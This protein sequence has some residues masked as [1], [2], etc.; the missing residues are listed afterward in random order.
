LCYYY[1]SSYTLMQ[2]PDVQ[3]SLHPHICVLT[4][5]HQ[6]HGVAARQLLNYSHYMADAKITFIYHLSRQSTCCIKST[7]EWAAKLAG[8][9]II[10]NNFQAQTSYLCC[11]SSILANADL[12]DKIGIRPDYVY[13]HSDSDL[14]IRNGV[15]GAISQNSYGIMLQP[16][17]YAT[18][19]WDQAPVM[20]K[21][22]RLLPFLDSIGC[23]PNGLTFGRA[24]GSFF[25]WQCWQTIIQAIRQTFH[26]DDAYFEQTNTHWTAEEI[27]FPTATRHLL[28]KY[29]ANSRQP[30]V[31]VK[32]VPDGKRTAPHNM[33]T[34]AE[35]EDIRSNSIY[36]GAK[37]FSP[38]FT[39]AATCEV[40]PSPTLI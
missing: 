12:I 25:S 30:L 10:F 18:W 34:Q 29:S 35:L 28:Q 14:L 39:D 4:P 26:K 3:A 15:V 8:R 24:E 36:Y 17:D 31:Y 5:V 37:R 6:D 19:Q 21:D 20:R 1:S 7:L 22:P 13:L 11:F 23:G 27:I 40:Y 33:I 9:D 38:D 16:V 2:S 32:P